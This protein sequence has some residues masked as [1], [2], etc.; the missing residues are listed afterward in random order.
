MSFFVPKLGD[1]RAIVV[2]ARGWT[3]QILNNDGSLYN[4]VGTNYYLIKSSLEVAKEYA[5]Q[6][7]KGEL[8]EVLIYNDKGEFVCVYR[9]PNAKQ[10]KQRNFLQRVFKFFVRKVS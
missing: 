9:N 3:G 10:P 2:R 7:I 8:V 4:G 5:E 6:E 1:G